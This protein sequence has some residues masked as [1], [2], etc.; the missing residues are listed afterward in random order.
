MFSKRFHKIPSIKLGDYYYHLCQQSTNACFESFSWSFNHSLVQEGDCSLNIVKPFNDHFIVKYVKLSWYLL[1][2]LLPSPTSESGLWWLLM[3]PLKRNRECTV[4]HT[5][6]QCS[7]RYT[8]QHIRG[9]G[10]SNHPSELLW[11]KLMQPVLSCCFYTVQVS[12]ED[13]R[14]EVEDS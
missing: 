12:N 10:K 8:A 2:A 6:S 9:Y 4:F 3:P 5:A 13:Q 1:V 11:P 14:Q 7:L